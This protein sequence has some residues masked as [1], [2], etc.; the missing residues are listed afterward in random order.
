MKQS[1]F[2]QIRDGQVVNRSAVRKTFEALPDGRYLLDI[3]QKKKRSN[4]QNA[5][6]WAIMTDYI[7]PALYDLGWRE[8]KNKEAAHDFCR[9]MFL[10]V[11]VVNEVTGDERMKTKSTT[12][13]STTEFNEYLEEISQWSAEFLGI[14]VPAPNEQ[15]QC[16]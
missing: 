5:Y 7:Q 14:T 12:E 13:L 11:K 6:Y 1:L 16:I 4:D 10:K 8:I 9:D 3:S 15:L 2:I